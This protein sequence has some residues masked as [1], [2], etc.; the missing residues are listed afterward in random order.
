MTEVRVSVAFPDRTL[1]DARNGE[2]ITRRVMVDLNAKLSAELA[3]GL[4]IE[5]RKR[6]QTIGR[7]DA[8]GEP[9]G[10][11]VVMSCEARP[12]DEV[13]AQIAAEDAADVDA[14]RAATAA[15]AAALEAS[16]RTAHAEM[17]ARLAES[18]N[19]TVAQHADAR[20]A[21]EF[22]RRYSI[23][24]DAFRRAVMTD[25]GMMTVRE[26]REMMDYARSTPPMVH[27]PEAEASLAGTDFEPVPF[28]HGERGLAIVRRLRSARTR[29]ASVRRRRREDAALERAARLN[30]VQYGEAGRGRTA[31]LGG[32]MTFE[33]IGESASAHSFNTISYL[34]QEMHD[35]VVALDSFVA[36]RPGQAL[37]PEERDEVDGALRELDAMRGR[38][39]EAEDAERR[40]RLAPS[41]VLPRDAFDPGAVDV[42]V[43]AATVPVSDEMLADADL[44]SCLV[45]GCPGLAPNESRLCAV[46]NHPSQ[47]EEIGRVTGVEE[48]AEGLRVTA[49]V[50][51]EFRDRFRR[52]ADGMP[53]YAVLTDAETGGMTLRWGDTEFD[54]ADLRR[55]EFRQTQDTEEISSWQSVRPVARIVSA[56]RLEAQVVGLTGWTSDPRELALMLAQENARGCPTGPPGAIGPAGED[57]TYSTASDRAIGPAHVAPGERCAGCGATEATLHRAT[58]PT[59]D[60]ERVR[61]LTAAQIAHAYNVPEELL[62]WRRTP[63]RC[64]H[65]RVVGGRCAQCGSDAPALAEYVAGREVGDTADNDPFSDWDDVA[66]AVQAV[67]AERVLPPHTRICAW[68]RSGSPCDCATGRHHPETVPHMVGCASAQDPLFA[69][70]CDRF[71]GQPGGT[72]AYNYLVQGAAADRMARLA[73]TQEARLYRVADPT[74]DPTDLGRIIGGAVS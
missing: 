9:A 12:S 43:L 61:R 24:G 20:R 70:D 39:R 62:S 63:D 27:Y 36:S 4:Q 31:L 49:T 5:G 67:R 1:E 56:S 30:L 60:T 66:D 55:V 18:R 13:L 21:A 65:S 50:S 58:C 6:V 47:R 33:P 73:F 34:R 64:A 41:E 32:G 10:V 68:V 8:N 69:C 3:E 71:A 26:A 45:V 23:D 19:A 14:L 28:D 54:E 74:A 59:Q 29:R 16:L 38:V 37:S 25:R 11:E 53:G 17:E 35:R 2:V 52:D 57:V 15:Q 51:D 42:R 7:L 48:D 72:P 40:R 46:H 44:L 22:A